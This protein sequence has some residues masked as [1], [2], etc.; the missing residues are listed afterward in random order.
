VNCRSM[1]SKHIP[2]PEGNLLVERCKNQYPFEVAGVDFT[3]PFNVL[4]KKRQK[5][6]V[7]IFT[8]LYTR[9]VSFQ[10]MPNR[11]SNSLLQALEKFKYIRGV[12]PILIHSDN[13]SLVRTKKRSVTSVPKTEW[14]LN[15]P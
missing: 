6:Y 15:P 12:R 5:L 10:V 1:Y 13:V 8:C 7:C 11:E 4:Q 14:R 2:I 9:A 3:G